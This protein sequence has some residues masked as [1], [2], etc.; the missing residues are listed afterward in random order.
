VRLSVCVYARGSVYVCVWM[1]GC[2]GVCVCV[3]VYVCVCERESV[4]WSKTHDC[5]NNPQ[6]VVLRH[7]TIHLRK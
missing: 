4:F 6:I 5:S 7:I 3:C 2:V 1:C